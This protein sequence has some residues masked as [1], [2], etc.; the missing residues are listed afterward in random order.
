MVHLISRDRI[1]PALLFGG[2]GVLA[3]LCGMAAGHL[4]AALLTPS[5]SPVLA[6]GSTVIDLTPTPLKKNAD[7]DFGTRA[8]PIRLPTATP[9]TFLL[10]PSAGWPGRTPFPVGVASGL[11][12]GRGSG[13]EGVVL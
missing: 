8:K 6:V 3:T 9:V 7:R 2:A 11:E 1:V 12:T 10:A 4:T 13:G 5:S